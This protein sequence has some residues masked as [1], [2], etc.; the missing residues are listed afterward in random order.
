MLSSLGGQEN[1]PGRTALLVDIS[2]SMT[3][4]L[5]QRSEMLRTDAAYGLAILL[6]EICEK[7]IVYSFSDNLA[8]VPSRR[9]FALRDAIDASQSHSGTYLGKAIGEIREKYDRIIVI[10][11]EQ[12]HDR[13]PGPRGRGYVINVA[14]N[15]NG[16]GY[17]AWTHI[18]GWSEAVVEYIRALELASEN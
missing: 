16:V 10:T 1:L 17:G 11:D 13:V 8:E 6:R 3:Y 7:A 2:G 18:D 15:K 14:S 5:S 4:A 9:G 12:A